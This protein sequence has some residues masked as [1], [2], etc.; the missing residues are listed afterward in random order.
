MAESLHAGD[1]G[2]KA[3]IGLTHHI[4][5]ATKA[6]AREALHELL[7]TGAGDQLPARGKGFSYRGLIL[8]FCGICGGLAAVALLAVGALSYR[9]SLGPI[10][11]DAL[12]PRIA[13]SLE[14]RFDGQYSFQL[15]PTALERGET[16]VGLTFQGLTI[17]D[18]SGHTLLSA[19]KG[20][21][22]LD[23]LRLAAFSIRA[24]KLEVVGV[25][26]ALSVR[27]DGALSIS[28]GESIGSAGGITFDLPAPSQSAR[29]ASV[30]SGLAWMIIDGMTSQ[31]LPLDRLAIVHGRMTIDDELTGEKKQLEDV[32]LAFDKSHGGAA[33]SVSAKSV[34]E[35]ASAASTAPWSLSVK[36]HGADAGDLQIEAHDINFPD[37]LMATG[38]RSF[39]FETD[40]PISFKLDMKMNADRKLAAMDGGFTLGAGYFKL[41]DPDHEPMLIDEVAGKLHWD[42]AAQ[43]LA[44]ENVQLF[45]GETHIGFSGWLAPPDAANPA[46]TADFSAQDAV[47]AA[48]RPGEQQIHIGKSNFHARYLPDDRR[49]VLDNFSVEGPEATGRMSAEVVATDQGPTLKFDLSIGDSPMTNLARLWPSFIAPDVRNWCIQ[50]VKGGELVSATLSIN[51]DAAAFTAAREKKPVPPDSVHAVFSAKDVT[52]ELLAGLP[53]MTGME[54]GGVLTGHEFSISATR[55]FIDVGPGRRIAASDIAFVV[56][57]LTPKPLN[58]AVASAHF[59]GGADALVDLI[60]RDAL[61]NY[62]GFANDLVGVKGHFDGKLSVDLKLGKTARPE[63]AVVHADASLTNLQIDKLVGQERFDQATMNVTVDAGAIKVESDGKLFGAAATIEATKGPNDPGTAQIAFTL[64]DA[65]RAKRGVNLGSG[66]SG[67]IGVKV[68]TPF[69]RNSGDAELDFT[70]ATIDNAL[71]GLVKPAGKPG[72]ATFGFKNDADGM[73]LTNLAFDAGGSSIKGSAQLTSD[74]ALAAAKLTQ[75]R[76]SPG[77][78]LKADVTVGDSGLKVV[79][80]GAAL[81]VRPVLKGL[82]TGSQSGELKN[83]DLDLKVASVIGSNKQALSQVDLAVGRRDGQIQQFR[84]A[85]GLGGGTLSVRREEGGNLRVQGAD[86]GALLK[87]FDFYNRM[88]KGAF[89]LTLKNNGARQDGVI[90]IHDFVLRNEPALKQL[91]AAGQD[92][93]AVGAPPVDADAAPFQKLTGRFSRSAGR[94]DLADALIY[95]RQMGLTAQGFIDY[96]NDRVDLSGTFV[97]AYQLNNLVAHVPFVGLIL[98]GGLHEGMFAVNYRVSGPASGPTLSVNPLSAV[99]PGF[100]RKIFGALDGTAQSYDDN[101][102]ADFPDSGASAPATETRSLRVR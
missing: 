7:A 14:E 50:N 79:V 93:A 58:P 72:K 28:A 1:E 12:N 81:D 88:E 80:R 95:D 18:R 98:G 49:F 86:A 40:M 94:I 87:F 101:A 63:D 53:P 73:T 84:L 71:P 19:P 54:G 59:Q 91:V 48:E 16:G 8:S 42:F 41:E 77:D 55:G 67:P 66:L 31:S 97:P 17:K 92:Q 32:N 64:D 61:K 96:A 25:N 44:I 37:I 83:L 65:T 5:A 69:A 36:A 39:A 43:H 20:K 11:L 33:F 2:H 34:I 4:D 75:L 102:P 27:P 70:R 100:L 47:F 51:W 60:S 22:G 29:R 76:M 62:V 82:F 15:G 68:K 10:A 90:N 30:F 56:P 9:L 74:G 24:K 52:A 38:A 21:V 3:E 23:L 57:D 89:D 46:W 45:E 78:D 35:G 6:R 99:T 13:Q 26:L 85:A